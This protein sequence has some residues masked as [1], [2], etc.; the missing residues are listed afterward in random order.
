MKYI[1]RFVGVVAVAASAAAT[2]AGNGFPP[3]GGMMPKPPF[4]P[5]H[6]GGPQM[7]GPLQGGGQ[8][9]G[10]PMLG[11]PAQG[12]PGGQQ[13]GAPHSAPHA[14]QVAMLLAFAADAD[15]SG[16]VTA[17]E[18]A[19]FLESLGA[20][21]TS[22]AV[23]LS[24]LA[25]A[26]PA[27]PKNAPAGDASELLTRLFD[28][29][30]DGTV[31]LD[32]LNAFFALL[33]ADGDGALSSEEMAPPHGGP[34]GAQ[35][36]TG[37][38]HGCGGLADAWGAALLLAKAA[39]VDESGDVSADEWASFLASLGADEDGVV[40]AEALAAAL[41]KPPKGRGDM[42][43]PMAARFDRDK[44]GAVD[45]GDLNAYFAMLDKDG[46]GALSGDEMKPGK[47]FRGA[48]HRAA[49]ALFRA[50]DADADREVTSEEWTS[51]LEGL[52]VDDAGVVSLDDLVSKLPAPPRGWPS[53]TAKRD[54]LLLHAFDVDKDGSVSKT[55][56]Q[57]V[58]DSYDK[59]ADEELKR[60]EMKRS[61][62]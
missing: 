35:N 14:R 12:G 42:R 1:A 58:F 20:D 25:G 18:W 48:D 5:M 36:P 4:P 37:G 51:F 52:T 11:G 7:D 62:K 49:A 34:G 44:S 61:R 40:D 10:G 54:A 21:A 27:P 55:D 8:F 2:Q 3:L 57:A 9:P 24:A 32:D 33:D 53:D 17:E 6:G 30:Q 60:G 46:D 50:A 28:K 39:D 43:R 47:A 29:D 16:D 31:T 13:Q 56:L 19:A 59:N 23:D 15:K 22:G 45:L 26:L 38:P 41:P